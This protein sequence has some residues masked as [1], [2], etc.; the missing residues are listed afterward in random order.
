MS[1]IVIVN[2]YEDDLVVL[3]NNDVYFVD[4]EY[5]KC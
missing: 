1:Y 5:Y 2:K 3:I 4:F